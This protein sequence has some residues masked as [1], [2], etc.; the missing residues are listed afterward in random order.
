[1][2]QLR[3]TVNITPTVKNTSLH[4]EN[5]YELWY[6]SHR[7]FQYDIYRQNFD[8]SVVNKLVVNKSLNHISS[9]WE[10]IHDEWFILRKY[11]HLATL[12]FY[13]FFSEH[14]IDIPVCFKKSYSLSRAQREL[15]IVSFIT[16]FMRHGL[17]LKTQI[18]FLTSLQ[19]FFKEQF[20]PAQ[21]SV[22]M[23]WRFIFMTLQNVFHSA[24]TSYA[25]TP[26]YPNEVLNYNHYLSL[27]SK[28]ISNNLEVFNLLYKNLL[29]LLP[30][31][32]FY[33]YKVDKKIFKNTRGKSGKFTFIWKYITPYKRL[34]WVM[35]WLSKEIKLK[36]GK[37][38]HS[39]F[40]NLFNDIFF[41]PQN[42]WVFKVK[43]FSYNY[44]YRNCRSTLA[45]NYR[46]STK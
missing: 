28:N 4:I 10:D 32:S 15:T 22:V 23:S 46:T 42:T 16:Y 33:I 41:N 17:K 35:Y 30:L 6:T 31:F 5:Y 18:L 19:D 43:R 9:S 36:T 11:D 29:D 27:S 40:K 21:K 39:R 37:T 44:V 3:P 20:L 25:T 13:E 7:Y 45:E 26:S 1:M 34:S 8:K 12:T 24:S 14:K 38:F 2:L